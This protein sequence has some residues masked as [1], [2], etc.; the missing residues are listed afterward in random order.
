MLTRR[1]LGR[2]FGHYM[3]TRPT[4]AACKS[5]SPCR[6]TCPAARRGSAPRSPS[7]EP[8]DDHRPQPWSAAEE[9]ADP[10]TAI[11]C[12]PDEVG[13]PSLSVKRLFCALFSK[14]AAPHEPEHCL[15]MKLNG[16]KWF[17]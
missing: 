7:P 8:A 13:C 9:P 5:R 17:E 16:V 6:E 4:V 1:T 10:G 2:G 3:N 11:G 12:K 15:R 14:E